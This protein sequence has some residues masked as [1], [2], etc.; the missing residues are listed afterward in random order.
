MENIYAARLKLV[1]ERPYLASALWALKII[2]CP[3]LRTMACDQWWRLYV[4]P[5]ILQKWNVEE[6]AGVLYHE[7]LHLLRD[8]AGRAQAFAAEPT[9]WNIAADLEVNDDLRGEGIKLPGQ[10]L[11][12]EAFGLS[13][14]RLAEEYYTHA[15]SSQP[16]AG[17]SEESDLAGS[18]G[19][20]SSKG[21]ENSGQAEAESLQDAKKGEKLASE[22]S[23]GS[24]SASQT[25]KFPSP[26]AGSCG[27]CTHGR[28]EPWEFG[29]PGKSE[30][31][32]ISKAEAELIRRKVAE[33]IREHSKSRGRVPGH[34]RRWAEEKLQPKVDWRRLLGVA[35]RHALADVAGASDYSYRRPSRRSWVVPGVVSP[36][37]R[38]PAP[39]VGVIVDTSGSVSQELLA[40]ALAEIKKIL[41]AAGHHGV[42][43]LS[44]DAA[45][46][47]CRRVF[48]LRQ[49][50]LLG[51]GGTD[52]GRGLERVSKL[53]PRPEVAIVIT[54]GHT[55]WPEK[56]PERIR[57]IVVR[58][59]HNS[60]KAPEWAKEVVID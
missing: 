45:V 43:V 23:G 28:P 18:E 39:G 41:R 1:K 12:P 25:G 20:Q 7:I 59:D 47:T 4:D 5:S 56:G 37:L 53:R 8:H 29:P 35:I 13:K 3:G 16:S 44:V 22:A 17:R 54:D 40:R 6:I 21:E 51:G 24:S 9:A 55:P 10:P 32:G 38:K 31:P 49:V 27:S 19:A 36:S 60:P 11:F 48:S 14:G 52:M 26:G 57:V 34:L 42:H 2:E 30:V 58:T 46:Q 50:E 15:S 33:E